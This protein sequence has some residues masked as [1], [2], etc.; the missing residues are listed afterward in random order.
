M[1]TIPLLIVVPYLLYLVLSDVNIRP[2]S[3]PY[4]YNTPS[5]L[6]CLAVRKDENNN[7]KSIPPS[8]TYSVESGPPQRSRIFNCIRTSFR[9]SLRTI[10]IGL[11]PMP[12][13]LITMSEGYVGLIQRTTGGQIRATKKILRTID[14]MHR[15]HSLPPSDWGSS[16]PMDLHSAILLMN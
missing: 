13:Q 8:L 6:R 12:I 15:F 1:R 7:N 10:F 16:L 9:S 11:T 3:L 14:D 5:H 2:A 4:S